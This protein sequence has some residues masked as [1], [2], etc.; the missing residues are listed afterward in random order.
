MAHWLKTTKA[1]K[2]AWMLAEEASYEESGR[3]RFHAYEVIRGSYWASMY[4]DAQRLQIVVTSFCSS[5][6]K[7]N[8]PKH[9]D[10]LAPQLATLCEEMKRPDL[11]E[12]IR[13]TAK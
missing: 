1:Q 3:A 9:W 7:T 13:N 11:A 10:K 12:E 5:T 2:Q 8:S 6:F 4:L